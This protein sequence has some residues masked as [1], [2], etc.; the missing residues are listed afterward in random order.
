MRHHITLLFEYHCFGAC[1]F[2]VLLKGSD[3]ATHGKLI[4]GSA[5]SHAAVE[6]TQFLD[7]ASP[8]RQML[9]A[10]WGL[11]ACRARDTMHSK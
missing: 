8:P 1:L 4:L 2:W 9:Q 6:R 11:A 10:K 5:P 3:S 7:K